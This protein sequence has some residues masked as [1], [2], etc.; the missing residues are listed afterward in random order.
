MKN[1]FFPL[2]LGVCVF[3]AG[4]VH[5]Q[6]ISIQDLYNLDI[7]GLANIEV[8]AASKRTESLGAAPS[9][10]NV[11]TRDDIKR[12]GAVNLHD[13]LNRIIR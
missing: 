6:D 13:I 4:Q 11:V 9:I 5:A 12:Y 8:S 2:L 1:R 7:E 3:A 10:M